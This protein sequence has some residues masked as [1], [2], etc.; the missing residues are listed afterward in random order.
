M[1]NPGFSVPNNPVLPIPPL[2][3]DVQYFNNLIRLL[4]FYIQKQANPGHIQGTDLKLTLTGVGA[5]QDVMSVEYII[6][7][8]NPLVNKT[9]VNIVDLPTSATGLSAGDVWNDSGT[10]KIV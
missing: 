6:D 1:K 8:A 4:N 3:Y 10:L 5:T 7:A 9:I 2:E